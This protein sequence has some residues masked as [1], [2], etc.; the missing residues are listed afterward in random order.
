M[1]TPGNEAPHQLPGS[2]TCVLNRC[3]NANLPD[4]LRQQQLN[5]YSA[6]PIGLMTRLNRVVLIVLIVLP[7]ISDSV[8]DRLQKGAVN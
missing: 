2:F 3:Q 5:S 6:T 7:D 1:S 4:P 8:A